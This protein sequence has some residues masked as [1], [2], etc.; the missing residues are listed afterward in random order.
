MLGIV[1]GNT[2][3]PEHVVFVGITLFALIYF[4]VRALDNIGEGIPKAQNGLRGG[5]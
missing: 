3:G 1:C 4:M 2:N 5:K